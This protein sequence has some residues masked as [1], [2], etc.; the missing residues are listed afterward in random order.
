MDDEKRREGGCAPGSW[1]R[2]W[3]YGGEPRTRLVKGCRTE[4]H[5]QGGIRSAVLEVCASSSRLHVVQLA[6][7]YEPEKTRRNH[8]NLQRS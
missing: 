1:C 5:R 8:V 3:D 6:G 4:R 7:R 2:D